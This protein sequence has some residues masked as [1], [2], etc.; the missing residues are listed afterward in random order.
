MSACAALNPQSALRMSFGTYKKFG[1]AL[2]LALRQA[3][4]EANNQIFLVDTAAKYGNQA[5]VAD[6]LRDY[7]SAKVG[8]KVNRPGKVV[9]DMAEMKSL[10]GSSLYRVILHRPM[11]L[12]DYRCL[13][14]AKKNGEVQEIGVSNY[15]VEALEN[16]LSNCEMAPDVVQ[17]ELHPC[18]CTPVV[19]LCRK[20]GIRFEA[21]SIM[22]ANEHLKPFAQ[23]LKISPA[24][25][26]IAFCLSKGA[27]VCFSTSN[28]QHL[29]ANLRPE[30]ASILEVDSL[31][32][33]QTLAY[34]HPIRL[35]RAQGSFANDVE[36]LH[37]QLSRDIESYQH[38]RPFSDL[39]I[40]IPKTHQGSRGDL[41]K[42]LAELVFPDD[43]S[44][45]QKFD[46]LMRKM[47]KVL[48]D[49]DEKIR[50]AKRANY[51]PKVCALPRESVAYP[52]ALPVDIPNAEE[53]TPFLNELANLA[54]AFQI[55]YPRRFV[56]GTLF[57]DGRMDMCKQVVQPRFEELC[58]IVGD[59]CVVKHFLLGNNVVF[60]DGTSDE[61][62]S[63]LIALLD[64][65][66]KNP[67]IETWYLAGNGID[68]SLSAPL[69][70]HFRGVSEL[71]ALWLK[72][73][74]IKEG[75]RFFGELAVAHEGLELLDLFN[76]GLC[77]AG[78]QAFL[79]GLAPRGSSTLKHLYLS[80]NDISDAAAVCGVIELL[81]NLESLFLGVNFLG[82]E[83]AT[84]LL[85]ALI[86]HRT[87]RRLEFGANGLTDASLPLFLEV[88]STTPLV[89]L[90]LGSYKSTQYFAGVHNSFSDVDGL[91]NIAKEVA[92]LN[93]DGS[94]EACNIDELEQKLGSQAPH[95]A[96]FATQG[97]V[98]AK[99][100]LG[101]DNPNLVEAKRLA[102]PQPFV[103]NIQSIYRNQ[104]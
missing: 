98:G 104:M 77:N 84:R 100:L 52:D 14:A 80:I 90:S 5:E 3:L 26:A 103:D 74:P 19:E 94:L 32:E 61:I 47:R 102:H 28:L 67:A 45:W 57:P 83:G 86:G 10:F 41:P 29:R 85:S 99:R 69:A 33:L 11:S 1:P 76:T 43:P 66:L 40:S 2:D 16:L 93:L 46:N 12:G 75:A 96:V 34:Q 31:T 39:C 59:C 64:L 20:H 23:R 7:P 6:I 71:K 60:R 42:R 51:A 92:Y 56:K 35:Y 38:G 82:D 62:Q 50:A 63:R 53:F 68:S 30:L 49:R 70:A 17:N 72:M 36:I 79:D 21:H 87:L 27:D 81:P 22:A 65:L 15:S 13:E 37:G 24:E 25:T 48:E 4:G 44:K 91:A 58:K 9:E 97:R 89:A 78:V 18:I 95:T 55:E 101:H 8:S 73:N 88:A 54:E